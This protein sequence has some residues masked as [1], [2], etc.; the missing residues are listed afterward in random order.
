MMLNKRL[1]F[2]QECGKINQIISAMQEY[3][4]IKI[5]THKK[6]FLRFICY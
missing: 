6:L 5:E 3:F 2:S 1:P 4:R